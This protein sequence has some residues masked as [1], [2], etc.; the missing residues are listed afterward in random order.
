MACSVSIPERAIVHF[1]NNVKTQICLANDTFNNDI[2][3][4]TIFYSFNKRLS[5]FIRFRTA[6]GFDKPL[7]LSQLW[8]W[9]GF[10]LG[11]RLRFFAH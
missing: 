8:F 4:F 11:F 7:F 3:D 9:L 6:R 10:R 2:F 5:A 1:Y